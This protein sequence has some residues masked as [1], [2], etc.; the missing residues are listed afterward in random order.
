[1]GR[2]PE[3]FLERTVPFSIPDREDVQ[4]TIRALHRKY[5]PDRH[6]QERMERDLST[7]VVPRFDDVSKTFA[8]EP[9]RSVDRTGA[10]LR[11]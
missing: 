7:V 1:V 2:V 8:I 4:T 10:R 9:T 5:I 11:E 6:R 3:T